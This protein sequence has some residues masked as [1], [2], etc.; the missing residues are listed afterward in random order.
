MGH[1][2]GARSRSVDTSGYSEP[3]KIQAE[4]METTHLH[5]FSFIHFSNSWIEITIWI[6]AMLVCAAFLFR[7]LVKIV[8]N[9]VEN[10]TSADVKLR[11]LNVYLNKTNC[12]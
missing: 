1:K 12:R 7:D 6:V 11:I 4:F 8:E 5:G 3:R 9:Y 10:P 2:M